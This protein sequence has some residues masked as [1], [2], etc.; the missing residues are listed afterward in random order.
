[1]D[2]VGQLAGG[3]AHDFNNLLTVI[4]GY[5]DILLDQLNP[6]DPARRLVQEIKDAGLRS[7]ALTKQLLLFSRKQIL[8]PQPVDLNTVAAHAESMLV[9]IIGEDIDLKT[10]LSPE[11]CVVRADP[12][13]IEQVILNLVV[14]ARDA[15]PNGGQLLIRTE[16]I[17]R[18][19][20]N[21]PWFIWR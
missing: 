4:N 18:M 15:M 14:N 7:A 5:S 1:M 21:P 17:D 16:R 12:G 19:N 9:R 3:V 2:A 13:R 10:Q 20:S 11:T 8:A 6:A